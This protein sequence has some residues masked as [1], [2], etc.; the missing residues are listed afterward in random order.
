[1]NFMKSKLMVHLELSSPE[2]ASM[3]YSAFN[4]RLDSFSS[5]VLEN[6]RSKWVRIKEAVTGSAPH[7]EYE[8]FAQRSAEIAQDMFSSQ[9]RMEIA[10]LC[11]KRFDG[12]CQFHCATDKCGDKCEFAHVHC[13]NEGCGALV[14]KKWLQSHDGACVHKKVSCV[15]TCGD[16]VARRLM[17]FHLKENCDLRPVSC[18]F[19]DI[20]CESDIV[21][22]NLLAH[23]EDGTQHHLRLCVRRILEQQTVIVALSKRVQV[24]EAGAGMY[25]AQLANVEMSSKA[26]IVAIAAAE[27]QIKAQLEETNKATEKKLQ[28]DI[29]D[30]Q[31]VISRLNGN[32]ATLDQRVSQTVLQVTQGQDHAI[33]GSQRQSSD[34]K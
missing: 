10:S 34:S 1:M 9:E 22:R 14:S 27:R 5:I 29:Q 4:H 24:L 13:G 31:T 25:N 18:T 7:S 16:C 23:I 33:S 8:I 11:I 32:F 20:G 2:C 12:S 17:D 30:L 21:F 28:R 3:E 6:G 15:R 19:C 26:N